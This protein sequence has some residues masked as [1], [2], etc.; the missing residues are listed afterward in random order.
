MALEHDCNYILFLLQNKLTAVTWKVS[1][2][3]EESVVVVGPAV[4]KDSKSNLSVQT[5][6]EI[7]DQFIIS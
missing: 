5:S 2:Q 7:R 6:V 3:F 4:V 1:T